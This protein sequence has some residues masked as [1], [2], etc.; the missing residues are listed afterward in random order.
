VLSL[1]LPALRE[2]RQDVPL[3]AR[4]FAIQCAREMRIAPKEISPAALHKL[5]S[6]H[7]PGNVRELQNII[8]RAIVLVE[9]N[10]IRPTDIA[11]PGQANLMEAK[12]FKAL[13]AQV[14]EAFE[15]TY[16]EQLL[17]EHDGNITRAA[18]A[19][20]KNRR[21]LWELLRKHHIHLP[22]AASL[23]LIARGRI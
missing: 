19:A 3:L 17:A 1:A 16:L 10:V 7:W 5:M 22:Q 23:P 12:S 6:Y 13:K 11:L 2:R 20:E 4:H 14:V 18:H 15:R 21:A 9:D 8:Q